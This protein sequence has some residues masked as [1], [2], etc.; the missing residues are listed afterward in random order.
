MTINKS[1]KDERYKNEWKFT[2]K[3]QVKYKAT[4]I[5]EEILII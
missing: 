4:H 3:M 5:D 2:R 1:N